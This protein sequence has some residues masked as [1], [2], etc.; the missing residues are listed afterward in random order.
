MG[1]RL[2][3]VIGSRSVIPLI[4][5]AAVTLALALALALVSMDLVVSAQNQE[6]LKTLENFF[7]LLVFART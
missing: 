7:W 5:A 2:V 4:G 6:M 1:D 3:C